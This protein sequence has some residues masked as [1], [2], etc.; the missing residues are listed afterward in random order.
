MKKEKV[1]LY[2]LSTERDYPVDYGMTC[3]T[4]NKKNRFHFQPAP[5][6]QALF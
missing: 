6:K 3:R 4:A 5:T 2:F 1:L